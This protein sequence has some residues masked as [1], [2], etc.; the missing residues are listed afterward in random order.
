MDNKGGR[1]SIVRLGEDKGV[2]GRDT[3]GELTSGG[4]QNMR[5]TV[6]PN[7]YLATTFAKPVR[8]MLLK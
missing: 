1:K 2:T 4:Y 6:Y 8:R 7:R 3:C 5:V